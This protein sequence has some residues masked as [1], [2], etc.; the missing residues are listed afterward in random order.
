M[1]RIDTTF[2]TLQRK[3]QKV[4]VA[5]VTAGDPN[6]RTTEALAL[7]FQKQGVDL[8][9]LG[10]P[11]SDPV[12]DGPIIQRAS[13]RALRH[14]VSLNDLFRSVRR[15]RQKGL[16]IPVVLLSYYN[17][18]FHFGEARFVKEA[19]QCGIDGVVVPDLPVE[20]ASSLIRYGRK[21][22]FK[23]VL[24]VAPTSDTVR[25]RKIIQSSGGFIYYVSVTGTTGVRKKLPSQVIKDVLSLKR[26]TRLPICVG[27]GVST[28]EE[29]RK[30]SRVADG[31]IVGSAI[32]QKLEKGVSGLA[33]RRV[34]RFVS[35]FA[36]EVHR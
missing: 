5:F 27:F 12:A 29:A 1:N 3:K 16:S 7:E 15:L 35:S 23:V 20:E 19:K 36:R 4:L 2:K 13:T 33:V 14:G 21:K 22:D 24:L 9:E 17:P 25:R 18:I 8:L 26:M 6:L 28:P 31:V 34:G 30:V 32:V 10:F 11:F